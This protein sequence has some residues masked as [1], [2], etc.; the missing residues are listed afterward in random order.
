M[1]HRQKEERPSCPH[2]TKGGMC[3]FGQACWYPHTKPAPTNPPNLGVQVHGTHSQRLEDYLNSQPGCRVEATANAAVNTGRKGVKT[4]LLHV[5]GDVTGFASRVLVNNQRLRAA[6][7]RIYPITSHGRSLEDAVQEALSLETP[8]N[9]KTFR[10]QC[11]PR[12]LERHLGDGPQSVCQCCSERPGHKIELQVKGASHIL[13]VVLASEVYYV[14]TAPREAFAVSW[15]SHPGSGGEVGEESEGGDVPCKAYYKLREALEYV[16]SQRL[17]KGGSWRAMDIGASPGGW[18]QCLLEMG[19]GHV[20]S[21]DPGDVKV[22]PASLMSCVEHI[23][24]KVQDCI[25]ELEGRG[26]QLDMA[27]CDMNCSPQEAVNVLLSARQILKAGALVVITFKKFSQAGKCTLESYRA[28]QEAALDLLRPY[29]SRIQVEHLF[30]NTL[31]E[32]SVICTFTK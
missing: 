1:L 17:P 22:E 10:L 11:F 2:F 29:C 6:V 30:A 26:E 13:A 3:K 20:V 7:T 23:R 24:A 9:A 18:T 5:Q 32:R 27:V 21:I 25:G 14:G 12:S 16:G 4:L 8:L 19:A 28:D 31:E 15:D